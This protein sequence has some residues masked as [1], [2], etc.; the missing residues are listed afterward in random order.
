MPIQIK[1][2]IFTPSCDKFLTTANTKVEIMY[3]IVSKI[4]FS[5]LISTHFSVIW[6]IELQTHQRCF[7]FF[8]SIQMCL[9]GYSYLKLIYIQVNIFQ[10]E[11]VNRKKKNAFTTYS[12]FTFTKLR[13]RGPKRTIQLFAIFFSLRPSPPPDVGR[14]V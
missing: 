5:W 1:Q 13:L 7:W 11:T 12:C 10:K 8:G 3:N 4:F 6:N 2:A 9:F 14:Y